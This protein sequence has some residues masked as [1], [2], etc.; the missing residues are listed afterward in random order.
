MDKSYC[1]PLQGRHAMVTGGGRGIGAAVARARLPKARMSRCGRRLHVVREF[2]AASPDRVHAVGADVANPE[3]VAAAFTA[4]RDRFGP[5]SILVNNA[6]Q[7]RR[8]PLS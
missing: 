4:A 3:E 6:G 8:A 2:A 1:I 7:V 5:L